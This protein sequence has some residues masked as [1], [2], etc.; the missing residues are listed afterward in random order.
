MRDCVEDHPTGRPLMA[1]TTTRRRADAKGG[2]RSPIVKVS[3]RASGKTVFTPSAR[4]LHSNRH[5]LKEVLQ[6]RLAHE[7]CSGRQSVIEFGEASIQ[8][9]GEDALGL[10]ALM[11]RIGDI[12]KQLKDVAKSSDDVCIFYRPSFGRYGST[13][14]GAVA[15][16]AQFGEFDAV[17]GTRHA[18]YLIETKWSRSSEI[19]GDV[20]RLK[21]EQIFRHRALRAYIT[22][23]RKVAPSDWD[24]FFKRTGGVLSV[25]G[26][27][28][29][30]APCGSQLAK[31]L[32]T[33]LTALTNTGSDVV[34]VLL[35]CRL[36][37]GREVSSVIPPDFRLVTVN[38]PSDTG[39]IKLA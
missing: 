26:I 10:W 36:A 1:A 38:C 9:Y 4:H 7:M 15:D 27:K 33:V 31:N 24:D 2:A 28:I 13:S 6:E 35:Y 19:R 34:D 12:C 22:A 29:P 37:S 5:P 3:R 21:D 32:G 20:I 18:I 30:V 39:F 25:E 11:Y 16:S 23:W 17:I 8:G 14:S